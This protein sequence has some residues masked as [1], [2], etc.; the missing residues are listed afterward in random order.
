MDNLKE[1]GTSLSK[2]V[3]TPLV[4]ALLNGNPSPCSF[5]DIAEDELPHNKL[6]LPSCGHLPVLPWVA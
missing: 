1:V 4:L 2:N 3:E 6:Y 5:P